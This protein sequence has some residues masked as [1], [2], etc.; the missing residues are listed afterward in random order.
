MTYSSKGMITERD[1]NDAI[2]ELRNERSRIYKVANHSRQRIMFG[3]VDAVV[4]PVSLSSTRSLSLL[5]TDAG[6]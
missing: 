3:L 5:G 6:S 2:N 1:S 4:K